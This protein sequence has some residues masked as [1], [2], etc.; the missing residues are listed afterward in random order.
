[1]IQIDAQITGIEY[2]PLLCNDLQAFNIVDFNINQAPAYCKIEDE[3]RILGISKW[4]SPKRTRSFPFERIYNTLSTSKRITVIPVVK[5]EG[6]DGDRDFIQ[7]DTISL[8]SLLDNYVILGY[9]ESATKKKGYQNKITNQQFSNPYIQSKIKEI[10]NYHSSA[11][12]W[13]MKQVKEELPQIIQLI[14]ESYHLMTQKNEVKMHSIDGLE[15]FQSI[16]MKHLDEFISFSRQKSLEAQNRE[17]HTTQP[18]ESILADRKGK[19]NIL[20]FLGGIYYLTVDEVDIDSGEVSL[21]EAKHSVK[22]L[23]PS[24]GEIK[25]GLIKMILFSNLKN[26]VVNGS[27][28]ELKCRPILKLTSE[29]L[30]SSFNTNFNLEN[31]KDFYQKSGFNPKQINFLNTLFEEALLNNFEINI[32][33]V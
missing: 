22:N 24:V 16:L 4:V 18:K 6:F 14:K 8:M 7:W 1:M 12:H 10:E 33:S 23:L 2:K 29:K 15:K 17:A 32:H 31:R 9:Y 5:D 3:N 21:I 19:I 26:V 20:N 28:A 30:K 27:D 11:V 25:D 13:N